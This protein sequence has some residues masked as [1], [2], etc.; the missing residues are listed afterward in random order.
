MSLREKNEK[1]F[2]EKKIMF[3]DKNREIVGKDS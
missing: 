2:L 3:T 1:C